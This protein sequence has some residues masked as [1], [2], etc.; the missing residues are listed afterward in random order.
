[1]NNLKIWLFALFTLA[2][3]SCSEES[4]TDLPVISTPTA[5]KMFCFTNRNGGYYLGNIMSHDT[6]DYSGWTVNDQKMLIDYRLVQAG[7]TILPDSILSININPQQLQR[8]YSSGLRETF[9]MLDSVHILVWQFEA[10]HGLEDLV[11]TPVQPSGVEVSLQYSRDIAPQILAIS[12]K[13]QVPA[14]WIGFLLHQESRDNMVVISAIDPDSNAVAEILRTTAARY[15]TQI[16]LQQ[17]RLQIYLNQNDLKTN[18]PEI[19]EAVS[20]AQ[21]SLD[22]LITRYDH[23]AILAG[24]PKYP[25]VKGRDTFIAMSG[26]LC[27]GEFDL[28]RRILFSYAGRQQISEDQTDFG[29][30]PETISADSAHYS[31]TDVTLWFIRAIYEYLLYSGDKA[32]VNDI[33]PA[34]KNAIT[35][36][37]RYHMD[38][39]FFLLHGDSDT[40][41]DGTNSECPRGNRAVEVQA[42]WYTALHIGAKLALITG[43]KSF[44]E[45]WLAIAETLRKNFNEYYWNE[46]KM[47]MYDH[48]NVTGQAD[49]K[50]RPNTIFAVTIPDLPGIEPLVNLEIQAYTTNQV[51]QKLTYVY[52]VSTLWQGDKDFT[53]SPTTFADDYLTH[54]RYNGMIHTWLSGPIISALSKFNYTDLATMLYLNEA[55]YILDGLAIGTYFELLQCNTGNPVSSGNISQ[56][57]SLAE[58]SRNMFQDIIGFRPN[59]LAGV[60][61]F[62]PV[63][64]DELSHIS[65]RL[66]VAGYS[67]I[68]EGEKTEPG[69][70]F[71]FSGQDLTGPVKIILRYSG[72]EEITFELTAE[73]RHFEIMLANEHRQQYKKFQQ[74]DWHFA[75]PETIS[76]LPED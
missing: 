8:T 31:E 10:E 55:R 63:L 22:A 28:V 67:L 40:W 62:Q 64:T 73:N 39:N 45:H 17:K 72:F 27:A 49:R 34:I 38:A 16:S 21:V 46:Y 56:A 3:L 54:S 71:K 47:Q 29:R 18:L 4:L 51:I 37:L 75:I 12:G 7:S 44:S 25:F 15:L 35:G 33:F 66:P 6:A 57:I 69:T 53:D 24:L 19:T 65:A 61:I 70:I 42:L 5:D 68:F 11:F 20:W 60:M 9:T 23:A 52:G 76:N 74:L 32:F 59:G 30:I 14:G 43:N 41:M 26:L 1:M 50:I 13:N 2:F 58:F 48:L 36:T